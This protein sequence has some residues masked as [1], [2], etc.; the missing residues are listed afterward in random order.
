M[1]NAIIDAAVKFR[2][3]VI[4]I[5]AALASFGL[6]Q[7]FYLPIDAVPDITN[8]Q[9]RITIASPALSTEQIEK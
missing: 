1:F 8:K 9:V 7:M 2:A 5:V 6:Y 3:F 4:L